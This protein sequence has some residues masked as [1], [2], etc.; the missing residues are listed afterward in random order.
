MSDPVSFWHQEH[1][2]FS[3][4]LDLLEREITAF[5]DSGSPNYTLMLDIVTYLTHF[6]E[7]HHHPREDIAFERIAAHDPSLSAQVRRLQQEHRVISA[8]GTTLHG[9]LTAVLDGAMVE[10]SLLEA[11]ADT[12]LTYYRHHLATEEARILPRAAELLTA[13]DWAAVTAAHAQAPDPL[14]GADPDE[15][16][17]ELRRM[18]ALEA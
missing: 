16:Y 12:Y 6:P 8:A 15:R 14:F 1:V 13:A 2:S 9:M 10:R 17:R 3:K 5:H 11:A 4:L 7:R 18:I